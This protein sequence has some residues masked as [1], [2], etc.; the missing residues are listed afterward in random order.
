LANYDSRFTSQN[1][2]IKKIETISFIEL[3]VI[4]LMGAYQFFRLK[5]IIENRQ[6]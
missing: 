1:E 3:A 4:C 6:G 5:T 2:K